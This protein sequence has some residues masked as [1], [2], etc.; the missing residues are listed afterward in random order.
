MSIVRRVSPFP[1]V[2]RIDQGIPSAIPRPWLVASNA[3]RQES[4]LFQSIHRRLTD[5]GEFETACCFVV[6]DSF[7]APHIVYG[8]AREVRSPLQES[9]HF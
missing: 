5:V 1:T 3:V 9:G 8:F 4:S 7:V 2:H 6:V